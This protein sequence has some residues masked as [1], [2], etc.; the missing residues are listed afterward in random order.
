MQIAIEFNHMHL[1]RI[2]DPETS[3]E[4]AERVKEFAAGHIATILKCLQDHGPLSPDQI[5]T[6]C[7]LDKF[8][9]CRRLPE[10]QRAGLFEPT[11]D[12]RLSVSG[13]RERIW[14]AV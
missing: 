10:G 5:A 7:S 4:A 13:R 1:A 11:G 14:R 9:V 12:T 3:H 6:K 8:Q 2:T